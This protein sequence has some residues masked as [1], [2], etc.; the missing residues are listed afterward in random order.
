M[1]RAGVSGLS[2]PIGA[3]DHLKGASKPAVTLLE[4][5]DYQCSYCRM[6][7]P[8]VEEVQKRFNRQLQ[9][10]FRHF[11]ISQ[12]HPFA[13]GAAEAAEAASA[14]GRFWEMHTL[15]FTRKDLDYDNLKKYAAEIGIDPDQFQRD[16]EN[17]SQI[18]RVQEDLQSGLESGVMGTPSFFVNGLPYR[19][20][21]QLQDL[22]AYI[23][24][25][26]A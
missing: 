11:P 24:S 20:S 5:G 2:L 4:Y 23:K 17:H 26:I 18:S 7:Y 9:F 10:I 19:G 3:R 15:L 8:I 12:I 16:M 25:K 22:S 6:A 1:S 13:Q 21:W 14:Q